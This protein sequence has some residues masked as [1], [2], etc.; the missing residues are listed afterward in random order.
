[1]RWSSSDAQAYAA[2]GLCER[3]REQSDVLRRLD[4]QLADELRRA[5]PL[6][7]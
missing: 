4:P 3:A 1:M 6:V 7:N 5:V 2:L